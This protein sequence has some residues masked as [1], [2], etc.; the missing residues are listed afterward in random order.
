MSDDNGT[1]SNSGLSQDAGDEALEK[2]SLGSEE[3]EGNLDDPVVLKK[4]LHD[5]QTK[6]TEMGVQNATMKE[7][8][9]ELRGMVDVL[10]SGSTT[11]AQEEKV[12]DLLAFLDDPAV[13]ES[14]LDDPK[15]VAATMKKLAATLKGEIANLLEARDQAIFGEIERRD[16]SIRE[17]KNAVQELR[18]DPDLKDLPD[19]TLAILAKKGLKIEGAAPVR[20]VPGFG[21][22][23]R[24]PAG[25][26]ETELEKAVS[27]WEKRMGYDKI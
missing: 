16:P 27:A 7:Q 2:D 25:A 11:K 17:L 3:Q 12:E 13:Q 9:A 15:N 18:K 14:L 6:V 22:G 4:R 24:V 23:R 19:S 21:G 26:S 20:P 5:T 8:L 10:K 1:Q